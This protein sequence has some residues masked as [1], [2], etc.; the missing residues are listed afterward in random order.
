MTQSNT[1]TV[2]EPK[3]Y[4]HFRGGFYSIL[5]EAT[6]LD[7]SEYASQ[8]KEVICFHEASNGSAIATLF[9]GP[10]G[11]LFIQ[12]VREQ[13]APMLKEGLWTVYQSLSTGKIWF[14]PSVEMFDAMPDADYISRFQPIA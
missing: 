6:Y 10:G 3:V 14:R 4:R 11:Q 1:D 8:I 5:G 12:S 7:K 13:D 2:R 9:V